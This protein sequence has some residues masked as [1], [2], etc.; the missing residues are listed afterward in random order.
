M[1][2]DEWEFIKFEEINVKLTTWMRNKNSM[3]MC[4]SKNTYIEQRF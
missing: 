4:I 3:K 2:T 1:K